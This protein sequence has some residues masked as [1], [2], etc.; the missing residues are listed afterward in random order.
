MQS[1]ELPPANVHAALS[2]Y[3]G[4]GFD[5]CWNPVCWRGDHHACQ[6]YSFCPH[7]ICTIEDNA[8][9]FVCLRLIGAAHCFASNLLGNTHGVSA[10]VCK[11]GALFQE[12]HLRGYGCHHKYEAV[13]GRI[14]NVRMMKH[15][16]LIRLRVNVQIPVNLQLTAGG[17]NIRG[18]RHTKRL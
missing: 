17:T 9:M 3:I 14:S 7:A 11:A 18:V 10:D 2:K 1:P 5:I 6:T 12:W 15:P 8:C 13:G 4:R 16:L